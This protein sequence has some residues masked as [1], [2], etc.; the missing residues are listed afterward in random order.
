MKSKKTGNHCG[1]K[2]SGALVFRAFVGF[3]V[4]SMTFCTALSALA[5]E[6]S[7]QMSVDK[8]ALGQDDEL[9]LEVAVKG[10]QD[11]MQ[12]AIPGLESFESHGV[13]TSS[14]VQII[15]GS[16]SNQTVYSYT[17]IPKSV[18]VF[19]LGP[20]RVVSGGK[21]YESEPVSIQVT[22]GAA[23]E[24]SHAK[25]FEVTGEVDNRSPFVNQQ[26]NYT[27][28]FLNRAHVQNASLNLPDFKGFWKE[29]LG[30]QTQYQ[31][32]INGT[33]WEITEM[34][35][36]LFPLSAGSVT[37]DPALLVGEVLVDAP[38][39]RS[40]YDNFFDDSFFGMRGETKHLRLRTTPITLNVRA[41]PSN[42]KPGDFSGLVGK[43]RTSASLS[44]SSLAV[45]D[46][47]T[48]SLVVEGQGNIRDARIPVIDLKGFK[49][50]DDQ[51]ALKT[52]VENSKWGGSKTFK[53]A[54]V[55][56]EKGSLTVPPIRL[57]Y[58]DPVD[59]AYKTSET[60]ALPLTVVPGSGNE[61]LAHV[62]GGPALSNQ[63]EVRMQGEDLMP[64]KRELT[65][66]GTELAESEE[67]WLLSITLLLPFIYFGGF[68]LERRRE[69]LLRL[70][71]EGYLRRAKAYRQFQAGLKGLSPSSSLCE[72]ASHLLRGYL[73]ERLGFDGQALTSADTQRKLKPHG[74]SDTTINGIEEFLKLCERAQYG[75]ETLSSVREAE[76]KGRLAALGK[77]LEKE[78]SA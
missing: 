21:T 70:D 41:L 18:G 67:T 64:I 35:F 32:V 13:S 68:A 1:R 50:Y 49:T 10:V 30:K 31:K 59:A 45:G 42:G 4:F 3:L 77:A 29:A 5:A 51:P 72:Q 60:P 40:P 66:S 74:I 58:F 71:G 23:K 24:A 54:L 37:I 47:T 27:F 26:I 7:V 28:R 22:K 17:L 65:S 46:S 69:R 6:V 38:R 56:L 76:L 44:K 55:P 43:F 75:G 52:E 25:N 48:L 62:S 19:R 63:K 8:T 57:T 20:A 11:A 61:S 78:I 53:K 2:R 16:T 36:A 73:G 39:R 12:P 33:L 15:N 34:R 9:Q 14:Q